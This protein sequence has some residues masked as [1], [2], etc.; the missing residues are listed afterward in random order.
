MDLRT[1][2][3][4]KCT[5]SLTHRFQ[6]SIAAIKKEGK[7]PRMMSYPIDRVMCHKVIDGKQHYY[8]HWKGYPV[9]DD[10]WEPEENLTTETLDLWR[11]SIK[12]RRTSRI[13]QR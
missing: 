2:N 6:A 4:S 13:S 1:L 10:T 12:T 3:C 7:H 11:R 8:I 9:E 5:T